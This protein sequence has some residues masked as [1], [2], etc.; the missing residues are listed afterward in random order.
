MAVLISDRQKILTDKNQKQQLAKRFLPM[1]S[2]ST[3]IVQV[4]WIY[5]KGKLFGATSDQPNRQKDA[6]KVFFTWIQASNKERTNDFVLKVCL[7]SR[8]AVN[9]G[10]WAAVPNEGLQGETC[11]A[12]S[13][14][15]E[16]RSP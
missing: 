14:L 12:S 13:A 9:V 16:H 15:E 2:F 7:C 10:C 11:D 5:S 8:A 3:L 6:G 4:Y 1:H